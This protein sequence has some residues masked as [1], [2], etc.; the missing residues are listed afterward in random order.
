MSIIAKL[1]GAFDESKVQSDEF[2]ALNLREKLIE[3][4]QDLVMEIQEINSIQIR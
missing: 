1:D 2:F 4:E 3:I